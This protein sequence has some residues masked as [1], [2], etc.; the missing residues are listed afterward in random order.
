MKNINREARNSPLAIKLREIRE[1]KQKINDSHLPEDIKSA[2]MKQ[3]D[4][5][6]NKAWRA[7]HAGEEGYE[8]IKSKPMM[9][10]V[11][12]LKSQYKMTIIDASDDR[13]DA[14]NDSLLILVVAPHD[15]FNK[16]LL[17]IAPICTFDRWANSTVIERE[18]DSIKW[19][20]EWLKKNEL[21]VVKKVLNSLSG[22][23]SEVG[24]LYRS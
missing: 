6:L 12:C 10:V 17:R 7:H 19:L 18:F 23:V 5:E 9:P 13:I 21:E 8:I 1:I 11:R 20:V 22:E 24:G 2:M 15:N 14:K 3:C 16:Y 4:K